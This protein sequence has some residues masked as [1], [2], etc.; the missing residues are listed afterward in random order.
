MVRRGLLIGLL[1]AMATAVFCQERGAN[2]KP[3]GLVGTWIE[4]SHKMLG[5][6]RMQ[7]PQRFL[8]RADGTFEYEKAF[9]P[10]TTSPDIFRARGRWKLEGNILRC[11]DIVQAAPDRH[12]ADF[13]VE[14]QVTS[15]YDWAAHGIIR[16]A[17]GD[18]MRGGKGYFSG[19]F[20]RLPAGKQ[21]PR[22]Q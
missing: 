20:L 4:L 17:G 6:S 22:P 12:H 18:A 21:S 2:L 19:N 3:A 5:K 15:F 11:R 1:L 14:W 9:S 10:G 7:Q 16:F 13:P 8:F